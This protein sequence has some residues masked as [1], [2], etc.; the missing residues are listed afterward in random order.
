MYMIPYHFGLTLYEEAITLNIRSHAIREPVAVLI[1]VHGFL[2][3]FSDDQ[4]GWYNFYRRVE[5]FAPLNIAN[6]A[7]EFRNH[8]ESTLRRTSETTFEDYIRDLHGLVEFLKIKHL[9]L[10][11]HLLG[12]GMGGTIGILYQQQLGG[13]V[14][15]VLVEPFLGVYIPDD[16][17][18]IPTMD[19]VLSLYFALAKNIIA[20]LKRLHGHVFEMTLPVCAF[21]GKLDVL[22]CSKATENFMTGL[23]SPVTKYFVLNSASHMLRDASDLTTAFVTQ[24]T[25]TWLAERLLELS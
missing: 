7:L 2:E 5:A 16:T 8:G 24:Q 6:Y 18:I 4:P 17:T 15:L 25:L 21:H 10:P 20:A 11:L 13:L 23:S 9:N 19:P 3:D 1:H 22:A 14:S 12:C